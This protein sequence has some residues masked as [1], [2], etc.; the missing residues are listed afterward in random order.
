MKLHTKAQVMAY[1][2]AEAM[3]SL[4]NNTKWERLFNRLNELP[5]MFTYRRVDLDG[6]TFPKEDSPP[7]GDIAQIYGELWSMESLEIKAVSEV[8]TGRLTAPIVEDHTKE[9]VALAF[10]AG[11]K[12]T[13]TSQGIKVY[14][15]ARSSES[16][17]FQE[18]P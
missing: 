13:T 12:F 18:R 11:V 15:Y 5:Y 9:L 14:G 1:V 7:T 2:G 10:E 16:P 8:K 4:I 17:A 3:T 6:N